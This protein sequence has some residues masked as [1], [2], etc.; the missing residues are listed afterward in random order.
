M[1]PRHSVRE[2]GDYSTFAKVPGAQTPRYAWVM[3]QKDVGN[4]ASTNEQ[5]LQTDQQLNVGLLAVAT[6][7]LTERNSPQAQA[8]K[9]QGWL[10]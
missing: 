1:R 9:G 7:A 5:K 3:A 10:M 2:S 4:A 6:G 8:Q